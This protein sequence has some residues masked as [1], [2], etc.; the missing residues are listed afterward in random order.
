MYTQK[1]FVLKPADAEKKWYLV[2]AEGQTVGRVATKI[3]D[4]LRG[5][6]NPQYTPHTDSGDFVVVVNA[7]KVVFTGR[8]LDNKV[9]YKHSGYVGGLKERTAREQLDRQPQKVLMAAVKGMLPKNSLGRKQ[10]TKL[11]VFAGTEHN[12][13]AQ[14][15]QEIKL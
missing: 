5:K 11:K 4:I 13:E 10:L 3:A 14:N 7:E 9:Y 8:K 1:S 2:N 6:T 12:H 15:P